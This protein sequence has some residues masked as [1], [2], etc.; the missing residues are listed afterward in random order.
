[1]RLSAVRRSGARAAVGEAGMHY[2]T[3]RQCWPVTT[4]LLADWQ[5]FSASVSWFNIDFGNVS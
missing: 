4:I 2:P 5:P 3:E 1:M